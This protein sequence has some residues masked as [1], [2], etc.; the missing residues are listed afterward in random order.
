MN[1]RQ[2]LKHDSNLAVRLVCNK[3]PNRALWSSVPSFVALYDRV[4]AKISYVNACTLTQGSETS[5]VTTTKNEARVKLTDSTL[6]VSG[7][8]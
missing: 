6:E 7:A 4:L 5:G 2:R 8:L 3:D 1:D